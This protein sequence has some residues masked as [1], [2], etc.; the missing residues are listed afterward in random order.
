MVRSCELKQ[1]RSRASKRAWSARCLG[2]L[3]IGAMWVCAPVLSSGQ[4][5]QPQPPGVVAVVNGEPITAAQWDAEIRGA[6]T[7][8][9][10]QLRRLRQTVLMKLIDTLLLE[11]AARKEGVSPEDDL[12]RHSE[13]VAVSDEEV[14]EA[15]QRSRNRFPGALAPEATH[16]IRRDLEGHRRADA[17][18]RLLER[19]RREATVVNYLVDTAGAE[20]AAGP[21]PWRGSTHA[22]VTVVE[23]CDFP[24]PF[25]RRAQAVIGGVL[26]KWSPQVRL[27]F[28]HLPLPQHPQAFEAAKAAVCAE[29]QGRFWELHEALFAEGQ[30]LSW[31]GL[32]AVARAA[33]LNDGEFTDCL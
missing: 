29:Q 32:A 8:F 10:D 12:R 5:P 19:L 20:R 22:P 2:R 1:R 6:L 7:Q 30:D 16:R 13:G 17:L 24:C 14:E 25:C 11:Q 28:R 3:M 18:R 31:L 15:Y 33:G 23:F 21:A 27:I 9:E 26:A 4:A